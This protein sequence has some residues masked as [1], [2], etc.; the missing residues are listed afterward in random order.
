MIETVVATGS[1]APKK[2]DINQI[3]TRVALV[4]PGLRVILAT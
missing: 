4:V 2:N 1:D 3:L